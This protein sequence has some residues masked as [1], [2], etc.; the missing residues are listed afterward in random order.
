[1]E[2]YPTLVFILLVPLASFGS[3]KQSHQNV[4]VN[5]QKFQGINDPSIV[6]SIDTHVS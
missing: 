3:T 1:M 4:R 6:Y 2:K 5:Q